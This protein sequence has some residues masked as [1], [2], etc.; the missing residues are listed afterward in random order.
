MNAIA[1]PMH[2]VQEYAMARYVAELSPFGSNGG[3]PLRWWLEMGSVTRGMLMA[4][5]APNGT[6]PAER[7]WA[8]QYLSNLYGDGDPK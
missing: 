3:D 5:Y 4:H 2:H 8:A 1:M 7:R 6:T